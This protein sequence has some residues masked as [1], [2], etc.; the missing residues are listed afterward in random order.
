MTQS[1]KSN[2]GVSS[3]REAVTKNPAAE[4]LLGE[5]ETY[6]RNRALGFVDSIG[7]RIGDATDRLDDIAENGGGLPKLLSSMGNG[8][9]L[10]KG[11]VKAL[12]GGLK[13]KVGGLVG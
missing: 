11:G 1:K 13:D 12:G 8:D 2:A 9:G 7:D 3:V 5:V 10:L 4:R 6:L